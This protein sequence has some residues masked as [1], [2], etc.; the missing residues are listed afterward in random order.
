MLYK[1]KI[2][3]LIRRQRKEDKYILDNNNAIIITK[4]NNFYTMI[5]YRLINDTLIEINRWKVNSYYFGYIQELSLIKNFNLFKVQNGT[6]NFNAIY[7]YKLDKFIIPQ[8]KWEIIDFNLFNDYKCFLCSFNINSNFTND[9][10]YTYFNEITNRNETEKFYF[11]DGKYFALIDV[12]GNII[13]N[14]LLKG[15]SLSKITDIIDLNDYNSLEEFKNSRILYC[16]NEKERLKEE[17]YK[18]LQANSTNSPY[19]D[20]EVSKILKLNSRNM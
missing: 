1:T 14:K 12:N 5:H 17:H 4:T 7:N 2:E 10:I 13:G 19:L 9:D 18:K 8:N 15:F 20:N 16:N 11:N 3:R 6:G